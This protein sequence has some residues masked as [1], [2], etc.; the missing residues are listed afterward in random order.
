MLAGAT[1]FLTGW[2]DIPILTSRSVTAVA[3][4]KVGTEPPASIMGMKIRPG[5]K[6]RIQETVDCVSVI[7]SGSKTMTSS[8]YWEECVACA[9]DECELVLTK[10]Q[11]QCLAGAVEGAHDNYGMAFYSPSSDCGPRVSESERALQRRYDAL[12]KEL[13]TLRMNSSTAIKQA[14]RL[15]S[16][17]NVSIGEYGEVLLHGGRTERIQ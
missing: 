2:S 17:D 5:R 7:K 11:L 8:D 6:V 1:G 3:T 15:R 14:L 10:E 13:E 9:A 4:V 16:D 12:K